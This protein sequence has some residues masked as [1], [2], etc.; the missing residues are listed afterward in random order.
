MGRS[1]GMGLSFLKLLKWCLLPSFIFAYFFQ[2]NLDHF[3]GALGV[4]AMYF[5]G[6]WLFFPDFDD[7]EPA[8]A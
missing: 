7:P 4:A 6:L 3:V 2:M 8:E 1:G 5:I